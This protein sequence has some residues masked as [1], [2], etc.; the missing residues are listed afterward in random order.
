MKIIK[1]ISILCLCSLLGMHATAQTAVQAPVDDYKHA[2]RLVPMRIMDADGMAIGI[3]YEGYVSKSRK[4]SIEI[5]ITYVIANNSSKFTALAQHDYLYI[6]PSLKYYFYKS[7]KF[8]LAAGPSVFVG[9]GGG[10]TSF[11]EWN[12]NTVHEHDY[13]KFRMGALANGY[14]YYGLSQRIDIGFEIG[15]GVRFLDIHNNFQYGKEQLSTTSSGNFAIHF[16]Y[17][18]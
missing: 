14:M 7:N 9:Y 6:N 12:M 3:S 4:W 1:P 11:I 2:L 15:L 16:S 17:K 13:E 18:L 8:K 10:H 5:P